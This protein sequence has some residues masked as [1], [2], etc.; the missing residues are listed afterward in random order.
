M[1][2]SLQNYLFATQLA[3]VRLCF[4]ALNGFERCNLCKLEKIQWMLLATLLLL[5]SSEHI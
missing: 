4:K 2:N 5:S 1:K 3:T